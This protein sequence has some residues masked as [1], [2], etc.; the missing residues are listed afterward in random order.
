[1][2]SSTQYAVPSFSQFVCAVTFYVRFARVAPDNR[3]VQLIMRRQTAILPETTACNQY[4]WSSTP[5]S[6]HCTLSLGLQELADSELKAAKYCLE[7]AQQA[8]KTAAAKRSAAVAAA[9]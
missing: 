3:R 5:L 2:G 7:G 1:M 9:R 8:E 4:S 6:F